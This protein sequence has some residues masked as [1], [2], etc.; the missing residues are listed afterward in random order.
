[1]IN[2]T[3]IVC[4]NGCELNIDDNLNVTGNICKRGQDYAL[5]EI[6]DPKRSLTTTCKTKFIDVPVVPVETDGEIKKEL[7]FEVMKLIN[8]VTIDSRLGIG[9]IVIKNV[10]NTNVNVIMC[11]NI[12][13]EEK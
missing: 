11:T 5:Q 8:E 9:E 13:K 7:M 1:M 4:P 3:C 12:L 2:L 6:K 10:L